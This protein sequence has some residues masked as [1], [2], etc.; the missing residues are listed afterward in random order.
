MKKCLRLK[1]FTISFFAPILWLSWL[2]IVLQKIEAFYWFSQIASTIALWIAI[3]VTVIV[4]IIYMLKLFVFPSEVKKEFFH[5]VKINF[6]P[7]FPKWLLIL[8][9][10]FLGISLTVSKALWIVWVIMNLIF[11]LLIFREYINKDFHI[12]HINPA[13][14]IPVVT[15]IVIPITWLVVF[16]EYAYISRF[17]FTVWLVF[18]M[19]LF[20]IIMYRIFFHDPLPQKLLP[21]LIILI[22]PP[23]IGFISY[24][25]LTW[26]VLSPFAMILFYLSVFLFLLLLVDI[27]KFFKIKF[28]LS[29]WA[30]SFPLA[31]F[32]LANVLMFHM[33]KQV[34]FKYSSTAI[35]ILLICIIVL[36]LFKTII[37]IKNKSLCVKEAE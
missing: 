6:F 21:T 29:R 20:F 17:F 30:Y 9:I 13:W 31:A 16:P 32:M 23:A 11:T 24:V 27:K 10:A 19:L 26:N 22:A 1:Y 3:L 33:T 34:F 8:S 36:L 5:P 7:A 2:T 35:A 28:Y 4:F 18:W 12:K 14:F 37:A 25:K 15:N